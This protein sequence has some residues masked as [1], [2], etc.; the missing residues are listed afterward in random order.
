MGSRALNEPVLQNKNGIH[1]ASERSWCIEMEWLGIVLFIGYFVGVR[2]VGRRYFLR[3]HGVSIDRG[4]P[5]RIQS[6][7]IGAIWPVSIFLEPVRNPNRC[8]H[9]SHVLEH[10]RIMSEIERFNE[11]KYRRG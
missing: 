9:Y 2:I 11:I 7:G 3:R 4:G 6:F 10:D 5:G 1:L 8:S